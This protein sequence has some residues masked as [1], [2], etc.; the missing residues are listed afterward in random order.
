MEQLPALTKPPADYLDAL[1]MQQRRYLAALQAGATLRE[2]QLRA[3]SSPEH[4]QGVSAQEV[5]KWV[6]TSAAFARAHDAVHAGLAVMGIPAARAEAVAQMPDLVHHFAEKARHAV[7]D[8]DQIAAGRLV[9]DISQATGQVAPVTDA[10]AVARAL[11]Q[12][13]RA[14]REAELAQQQAQDPT[15]RLPAPT[16]GEAP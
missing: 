14:M 15:P 16:S 4:S 8:R 7:H 5:Q 3:G 1:T 12:E 9:S 2:A 13:M 6:R 11:V 10:A